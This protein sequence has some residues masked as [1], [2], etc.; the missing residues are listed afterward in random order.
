MEPLDF[1]RLL[2]TQVK[3]RRFLF[4]ALI[5]AGLRISTHV[6]VGWISSS[7]DRFGERLKTSW[8]SALAARVW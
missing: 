3:R 7:P 1:Q 2:S 4:G 6:W 8:N 5:L